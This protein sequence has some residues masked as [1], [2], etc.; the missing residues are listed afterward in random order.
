[1]EKHRPV[2]NAVV[3]E[4][5]QESLGWGLEGFDAKALREEYQPPWSC[6]ADDGAPLNRTERKPTRIWF[7]L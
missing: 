4:Q 7:G 6:V 1:M 3:K 5:L 2:L